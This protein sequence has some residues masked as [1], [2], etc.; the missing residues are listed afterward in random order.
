[1]AFDTLDGSIPV[2]AVSLIIGLTAIIGNG[3]ILYIVLRFTKFRSSICNCLIGLLAFS[4]LCEGIGVLCAYSYTIYYELTEVKS[5]NRLTCI[6]V[7]SPGIF[8]V[9]SGQI[10]M[11][12]MA[13]D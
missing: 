12:S 11:L 8:G 7:S 9:I 2:I 4:E 3:I 5:F 10:T 13:I 6:G 1:M